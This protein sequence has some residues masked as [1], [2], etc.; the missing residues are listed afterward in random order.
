[1]QAQQFCGTT[2]AV[3]NAIDV[4]I[5]LFSASVERI[6]LEPVQC[7]EISSQVI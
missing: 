5:I 4:S 1:M 3:A 2:V 6:S 7:I